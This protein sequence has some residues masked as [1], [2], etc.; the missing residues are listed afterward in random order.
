[1]LTFRFL[2]STCFDKQKKNHCLSQWNYR[3]KYK[4][5]GMT[6]AKKNHNI[7]QQFQKTTNWYM[8]Q[9]ER[10]MDNE[11]CK[12]LKLNKIYFKSTKHLASKRNFIVKFRRITSWY[13][14]W[15]LFY[16]NYHT[17]FTRIYYKV[18]LHTENI[19]K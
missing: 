14:K 5:N 6:I 13:C 11:T 16:Q 1:M 8:D 19:I 2:F 7:I 17:E 15:V 10:R 18:Y 3:Q 4:T 12:L 9:N